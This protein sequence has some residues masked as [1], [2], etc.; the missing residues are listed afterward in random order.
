MLGNFIVHND[1]TSQI[2]LEK[3]FKLSC[4]LI[5][6]LDVFTSHIQKFK[7]CYSSTLLTFN[8]AS[9][10]KLRMEKVSFQKMCQ[11]Q[12]VPHVSFVPP[13]EIDAQSVAEYVSK[14]INQKAE[15]KSK[16]GCT[17]EQVTTNCKC[18]KPTDQKNQYTCKTINRKMSFRYK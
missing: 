7:K 14:Q 11:C 15:R 8:T 5:A 2:D 16:S 9:E 18:Y 12:N 1:L 10:L 6:I 17:D 4:E 3:T 13:N